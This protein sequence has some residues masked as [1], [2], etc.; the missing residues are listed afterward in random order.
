[1]VCL[2]DGI[3]L[4][5]DLLPPSCMSRQRYPSWRGSVTPPHGRCS[6]SC[7]QSPLRRPSPAR[8]HEAFQHWLAQRGLLSGKGRK[9]AVSRCLDGGG[10]VGI[11]KGELEH[12]G[13]ILH[14]AP[15]KIRRLIEGSPVLLI[16]ILLRSIG[17]NGPGS[18]N[19]PL[20]EDL[21]QSDWL[22]YATSLPAAR[23]APQLTYPPLVIVVAALLINAPSLVDLICPT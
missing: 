17:N 4:G 14:G 6:P 9:H 10:H 18:R 15:S 21:S 13:I 2:V 11:F 20:E 19:L 12:M 22:V 1:M 7:C 3:L 8:R 16:A 5:E 23:R